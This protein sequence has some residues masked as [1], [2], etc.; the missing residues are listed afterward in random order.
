MTKHV[1]DAT[2]ASRDSSGCSNIYSSIHAHART[3]EALEGATAEL[4]ELRKKVSDA[5]KIVSRS[6]GCIDEFSNSA[7][8]F[9]FSD[10]VIDDGEFPIVHGIYVYK[11]KRYRVTGLDPDHL[12]QFEDEWHPA[13]SY[14]CEPENGK[15]FSRAMPDFRAKFVFQALRGRADHAA[16]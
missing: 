11:G 9:R 7:G 8:K 10:F 2:E 12:I 15:T 14:V 5:M 4:A 1:E 6:F 3:L 13:V 16:A